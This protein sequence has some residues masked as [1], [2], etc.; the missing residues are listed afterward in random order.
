M[1]HYLSTPP[2]NADA[3]RLDLSVPPDRFEQQ[4][5]YFAAQGFQTVKMQTLYDAVSKGT[6][7][8]PRS[9]VFTFDDGYEDAYLNAMPILQKYHFIGTF[10]VITGFVG[11]PGYLTWGEI[12]EMAKAGMDI[13][14]HSVTH[15]PM[16]GK[17]VEVLQ[18]EM[19]QSKRALEQMIGQPVNFFCYP[20]GQYDALAMTVLQESGYLAATTT[21]GGVWENEALPFE[22]PRIRIHGHDQLSDVLRRLGY[23]DAVR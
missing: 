5:A 12:V 7:L 8:P 10:F 16:R 3:I 15:I 1:Y 2:D 14:S 11:R 9:V 19:G 21:R 22:W 23:P 6:P 18:R 20:S 13:E 17:T 4:V